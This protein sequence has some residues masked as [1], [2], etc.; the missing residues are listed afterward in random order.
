M[1]ALYYDQWDNSYIPNI[2]KEI[3]LDKVYQP[4]MSHIQDGI[5]LDLGLNI[6][7]FSQFAAKY[8]KQVYGFEPAR[9][10]YEIALKNLEEATNVKLLNKAIAEKDGTMTF[11]R[12]TNSTMNSL[13]ESVDD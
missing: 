1:P 11:Y 13:N 10:S 3:Y 6:G 12:N 4:Y 9:E 5:V 8:A 2:L 7:L